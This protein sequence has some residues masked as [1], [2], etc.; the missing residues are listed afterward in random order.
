MSESGANYL[1]V[2]SRDYN[3]VAEP[4]YRLRASPVEVAEE[5]PAEAIEVRLYYELH[6]VPCQR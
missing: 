5:L 4:K 3:V 6:R 2:W 1:P